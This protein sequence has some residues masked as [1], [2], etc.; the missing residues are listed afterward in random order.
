MK[1]VFTL[2]EV[3]NIVCSWLEENH[4]VERGEIEAFKMKVDVDGKTTEFE[5]IYK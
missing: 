5:I 4:H 2:D 1:T 3:K